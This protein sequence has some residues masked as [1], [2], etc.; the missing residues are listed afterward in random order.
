MKS[1]EN[2]YKGEMNCGVQVKDFFKYSVCFW[3]IFIMLDGF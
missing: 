3:V 2:W 1:E